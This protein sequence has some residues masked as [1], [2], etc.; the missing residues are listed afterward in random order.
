MPREFWQ[1]TRAHRSRNSSYRNEARMELI[2][3]PLQS[4]VS[5]L[6]VAISLTQALCQL[7]VAIAAAPTRKDLANQLTALEQRF[8]D[9]SDHTKVLEDL[10]KLQLSAKRQLSMSDLLLG[11]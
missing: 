1:L 5:F 7:N 11:K 2:D 10:K 8:N 3:K 9:K 4:V 6:L